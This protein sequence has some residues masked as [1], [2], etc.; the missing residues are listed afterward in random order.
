M[1]SAARPITLA[2]AA[3]GGQGGGV[4]TGWLTSVARREGYLVQATSVPG[5][6]QRTGATLYYLEFFAEKDLPADGRRPVMALMP[7]PGD[8]DVVVATE[9]LEAVR[10]VQRGLVTAERTILITST[11]RAY[12]ISEKAHTGDGRA[13]S[14]Q[15]LQEA[16]QGA[17]RLVML[18]MAAL[19]AEQGAIISAVVLGAIA[20]A[21]ALPFAPES[22][23]EAIA[24]GGTAVAL[25][26]AAFDASLERTR[27][28][29]A[30]KAAPAAPTPAA[31]PEGLARQIRD[32][33]VGVQPILEHGVTRLIDYQDVA[34]AHEYLHTLGRIRALEDPTDVR[35]ELTGSVA[36]GLALWMSVEDTIR[37]AQQ[38]I[39]PQRRA[40]LRRAARLKPG[41]LLEVREFLRPRLEELCGTLPAGLGRRLL[42]SAAWRRR[43]AR[44]TGERTVRT[45]SVSGYL[46]LRL[47]AGLRR[48]RRGT[49][50]HSLEQAQIAAWLATIER[51]APR[52]YGLAVR[53]ADAQHLVRGYGET[54][55][56]GL[57]N[58]QRVLTA[59]E[60]LTGADAA[61]CLARLLRAGQA[62]DEGLAM[63]RELTALGLGPQTAAPAS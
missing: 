22:Y 63:Q 33:P 28:G 55:E 10:S 49:L 46:L 51:L 61:E 50:R 32:F 6:A 17:K 7:N 5:V 53:V 8:V 34:Y 43:L 9:L 45:T 56:R 37:V 39:R 29:A 58:F 3:L 4:V 42:A 60:R 26:I 38:K 31:V 62:D 40:A 25:N 21:D 59:A 23:R 30:P 11:H 12:T 15:L 19:A 35:A 13:D 20:G 44:F 47:V 52:D 41:Q 36:R 16:R 27:A 48:W 2:L 1:S 14:G 24:E 57:A 54:Y 18:D